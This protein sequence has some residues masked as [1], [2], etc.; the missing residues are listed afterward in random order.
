MKDLTKSEI[1]ELLA[2]HGIVTTASDRHGT[3]AIG[4][5]LVNVAIDRVTGDA[6]M[7]T[8]IGD[9]SAI[10]PCPLEDAR[11]LE[12]VERFRGQGLPAREPHLE[13][14]FAHLLVKLGKMYVDCGAHSLNCDRIRLHSTSYH[15]GTVQVRRAAERDRN[16]AF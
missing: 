8:A 11:A 1:D 16:E 2:R 10:D 9:L 12:I 6:Y 4:G 13:H 7:T 14:M 15:I 3:T 5:I